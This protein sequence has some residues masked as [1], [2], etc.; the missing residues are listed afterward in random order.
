MLKLM[1]PI[2]IG[3]AFLLVSC[4]AN[5]AT[6]FQDKAFADAQAA[7]KTILVDVFAPWCPVCRKQQTTIQ[8]IQK[9]RPSLVVFQI[10]YDSSKDLLKRFNVQKQATLI[11]FKGKTE[12]GRLSYDAD[13]ANIRALIAKGF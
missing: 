13:P 8:S 7:G 12:V 9:E 2:A 3:L 1:R 5:A 11:M 4:G 10:D 6:M